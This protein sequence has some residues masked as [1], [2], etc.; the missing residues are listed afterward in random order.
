[1]A[2]EGARVV[3]GEIAAVGVDLPQL[4]PEGGSQ[5]DPGADRHAVAL[6]AADKLQPQP[7]CCPARGLVA[8]QY[9][10]SRQVRRQGIGVAVVVPVGRRQ[11]AADDGAPEAISGWL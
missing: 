1:E 10:R 4:P 6:R 5:S 2:E 3:R 8:Q 11:G 7:V 9:G